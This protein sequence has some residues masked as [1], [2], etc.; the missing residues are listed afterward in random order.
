MKPCFFSIPQRICLQIFNK[1]LKKTA[2][3]NTRKVITPFELDLFY[4]E[5]N[6][7]VEYCGKGW[8]STNEAMDRDIKK[9]AICK[10]KKIHLIVIV[11][12]TRRYEEDIKFQI[13]KNLVTLNEITNLNIT[14]KNVN[15]CIIDYRKIFEVKDFDIKEIVRTI[16][17]YKTIK[18][19]KKENGKYWMILSRLGLLHLLDT[20]RVKAVSKTNEALIEECKNFSLYKDFV[21]SNLYL[22]C[23]RRGLLGIA[24]NHMIRNKSPKIPV[25]EMVKIAKN[26]DRVSD[27]KKIYPGYCTKLR[28]LGLTKTIFPIS[29]KGRTGK[30]IIH[31]KEMIE[32]SKNYNERSQFK[33]FHIAHYRKA[34]K[35]KMLDYLFPN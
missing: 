1:I 30:H 23:Y 29:Y 32:L 5:Y 3:Y 35:L 19:F 9:I 13:I 31:L 12:N 10:E 24:T 21:N 22:K 28:L 7:A 14:E 20:L 26:Y 34:V 15:D 8:H 17:N 16:S 27:F 25:E 18:D 11:E 33:K 2:I 4:K 6:I